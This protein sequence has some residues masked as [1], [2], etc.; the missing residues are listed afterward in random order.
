M[1]K[2]RQEKDKE[3]KQL[4]ND[5]ENLKNKPE[6]ISNNYKTND[7]EVKSLL[8]SVPLDFLFTDQEK[9]AMDLKNSFKSI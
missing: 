4:K 1:K 5:I 9:N 2:L 7:S 3:I 8:V 6:K